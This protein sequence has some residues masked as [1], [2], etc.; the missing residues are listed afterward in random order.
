MKPSAAPALGSPARL[1]YLALGSNLG[2]RKENLHEALSRL[3]ARGVEVGR[4]SA[5][6]ETDP[7]GAP[8]GTETLRYLNAAAQIRTTLSPRSLL[9]LLLEIEREMG[10]ARKAGEQNAPRGIDLDLL[11]YENLILKEPG[12]QIPHPRLHLR[13]FVLSPLK[14]IAPNAEHPVFQKS[15]SDL[16]ADLEVTLRH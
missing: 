7:V 11:L 15:I 5:F 12:L 1:A 9:N 6:L 13:F 8:P 10:R 3:R 2:D 14:E 16:C 4:V